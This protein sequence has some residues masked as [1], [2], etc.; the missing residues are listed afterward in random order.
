MAAGFRRTICFTLN[1]CRRLG[2]KDPERP[3]PRMTFERINGRAVAAMVDGEATLKQLSIKPLGKRDDYEL[4]LLPL[5]PEYSPVVIGP[6]S[7]A[8]FQGVSLSLGSMNSLFITRRKR[9]ARENT[10]ALP[11]AVYDRCRLL[12]ARVAPVTKHRHTAQ[13]R[14]GRPPCESAGYKLPAYLLPTFSTAA[15]NRHDR[16]PG[17]KNVNG[18]NW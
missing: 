13:K 9:Q 6:N 3:T 4:H 8:V 15:G 5:N 7:T 1:H 14:P 2:I 18:Q 12:A 16:L 17:E 11:H 10:L